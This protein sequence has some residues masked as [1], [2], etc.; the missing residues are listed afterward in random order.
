M[1]QIDARAVAADPTSEKAL[2]RVGLDYRRVE[3][4]NPA[5]LDGFCRAVARGFLK[6]EPT[7]VEIDAQR[8]TQTERRLIGVYDETGS[9]PDMP[10]ATVSSWASPLT[11]PG[12][13]LPMWAI[14]EVTV[15]PTHRR[16]GIARAMIEGELRAA[17]DAGAAIAGLTASEATIYG[18]YG[19]GAASWKTS[20]SIDTR[21]ARWNGAEPGGK[22]QYLDRESLAEAIGTVHERTRASRIGD[23]AGWPLNWRRIAGAVPGE[24]HATSVRGIRYL[25]AEGALRGA[26]A[27]RIIESETDWPRSRL[28]IR[29]LTGETPAARAAL[30]RFALQHDLIGTVTADTRPIDEALPWMIADARAAVRTVRDHEWLRILDVPRAL[31]ARGFSTPPVSRGARGGSARLRERGVAHRSRRGQHVPSDPGGGHRGRDRIGRIGTVLAV[32]R[33]CLGSVAGRGG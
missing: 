20:W 27:Y 22:L 33:R 8:A 10:A 19:F 16:R 1:S 17:A 18:R 13:E 29:H 31:K 25:D 2:K 23:I 28:E 15:A 3:P 11:V 5:E 30:W 24:P 4:A 7:E 26:M 21:R 9:R 14:S 32:S 12:G 6:S